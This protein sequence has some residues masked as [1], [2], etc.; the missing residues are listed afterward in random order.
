[1]RDSKELRIFLA[2]T[3]LLLF[4][5]QENQF[6]Q[7][8]NASGENITQVK[9][10]ICTDINWF[11]PATNQYAV[12]QPISHPPGSIYDI[13]K[14]EPIWG[15]D[16]SPFS[17]TVIIRDFELPS[18]SINI[19]GTVTFVADDGVT[20]FLNS[21][22]VGNYDAKVW[23]PPEVQPLKNLQP[24]SNQFEAN[25]Y[26]R[27]GTAWFEMCASITYETYSIV[28]APRASAI[29]PR[30]L[31]LSYN[32]WLSSQDMSMFEYETRP[33]VPPDPLETSEQMHLDICNASDGFVDIQVVEQIER[34][35]FPLMTNG[36]R[37][38]E[39][40]YL[41]LYSQGLTYSDVYPGAMIDLNFAIT[42][43]S[44][45]ERIKN[46]EIDEVWYFGSWT[47][48]SYES[49]MGGPGAFWINGPTFE[50][51][52]GRAFVVQTFENRLGIGM[53]LHGFGHRVEGILNQAYGNIATNQD[54]PWARYAKNPSFPP[55]W[56][57]GVPLGIGDIHH[58]PNATL[59]Y[60]YTN[61]TIVESSADDWFNYPN[62]TGQTQQ[63]NAQTWGNT[64]DG[65]LQWWHSHLPKSEGVSPRA[66]SS[67][68]EMRQNN[69]WKYIFE[70]YRYAEL[71][72]WENVDGV[73]NIYLPMLRKS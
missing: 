67:P 19:S 30:V 65:F 26:N 56:I 2:M 72:G 64:Q 46:H 1:M 10:E 61:Q 69:W 7:V 17:S 18:D 73:T 35:E 4:L 34:N 55:D 13:P 36:L 20:L 53:L 31:V 3:I 21:I 52:S 48:S 66:D 14:A 45:N 44:I 25:I 5:K 22:E 23:P 9:V 33:A 47:I 58:P 37:M 11:E 27:P 68:S 12:I 28:C 32:P 38:D 39:Q 59:D 54:T 40:E 6:L 41:S 57:P 62:M 50:I 43:D 15:Q 70:F 51:D 71:V 42:D 24:G 63:V 16:I 29:K 8:A 49:Q 60:D